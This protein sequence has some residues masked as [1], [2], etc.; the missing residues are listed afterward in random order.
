MPDART[1]VAVSAALALAACQK[2]QQP[3]DQNIVITNEIPANA[4]IE[5]LPADES[6]GTPADQLENGI[7]NADVS[8]L[9][10]AQNSY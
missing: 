4:D 3:Q 9:N 10:A 2:T 5:T 1:L 6:A 8:D 7:D